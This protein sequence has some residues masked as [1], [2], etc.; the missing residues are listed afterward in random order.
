[1]LLSSLVVAALAADANAPHPHQGVLPAYTGAPP[2]VPLT[3]EDLA[4]LKAGDPVHKQVQD[5]SGDGASGR[6]VAIQDVH[7]DPA[8]VW[9]RITDF[10]RYPQ[11]VDNVK[12]C[13][14]EGKDGEMID[15]HF[16]IGA[17]LVSIEYWIRHRYQPSEGW[18]TWT[19][20][21]RKHSDFDDSVGFWRVEPHPDKDGWSR[22]FYSADVRASGWVPAPIENAFATVGLKRAT[23]WVKRESEKAAGTGG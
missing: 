21:Y 11:M 8:T 17:P 2:E 16:V 15:V 20:D 18:M 13:E 7:A 6:G 19:L 23:A 1:M 5:K 22:V 9:A 4:T 10:G 12:S 3:A 14:V